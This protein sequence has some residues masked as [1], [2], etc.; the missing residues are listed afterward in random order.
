MTAI[1]FDTLEFTEQL[2][3]SGVPDEQ[4]KGHA[5]AMVRLMER[6]EESWFQ[7]FRLRDVATRGDLR[8]VKGGL[9]ELG[10]KIELLRTE[11][12]A[13]IELSRAELE[14][15]IELSR[16]ELE[17]KL[18]RFEKELEAKI[19]RSRVELEARIERSETELGTRIER[20][21]AELE[22]RIELTRVE[23]QKEIE[24]GKSETIRWV[25]AV[26]AGQAAFILAVLK[27]FPFH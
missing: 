5:K 20:S 26:S 10:A 11:L 22:A 13:K 3:A 15:K 27:L 4:A 1:T 2:R 17:A 8:D 16:A 19:E 23:L 7:E 9:A 25:I 14:A 12:E 21:R 6:V 18:E 24:K